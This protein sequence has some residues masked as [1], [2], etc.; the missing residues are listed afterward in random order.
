MSLSDCS[1]R[2]IALMVLSEIG[3]CYLPYSPSSFDVRFC[4]V[5]SEISEMDE[6]RPNR[7]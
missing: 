2:E 6:S 4:S 3:L 7:W 5:L 1:I